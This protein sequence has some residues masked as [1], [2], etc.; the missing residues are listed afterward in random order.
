MNL[1]EM[2]MSLYKAGNTM[3][4]IVKKIREDGYNIPY[5][6]IKQVYNKV[7]KVLQGSKK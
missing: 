5:A 4:Q 7:L 3:L 6:E 1:F 2:I